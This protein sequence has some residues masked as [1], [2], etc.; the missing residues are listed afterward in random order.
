MDPIAWLGMHSI[1]A[2]FPGTTAFV[3]AH[4]DA[5]T[6]TLTAPMIAPA[7]ATSEVGGSPTN[8]TANVTL[9]NGAAPNTA[10]RTGVIQLV[11]TSNNNTVLA[12]Q[13][14]TSATVTS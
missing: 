2:A 12:T 7:I 9:P 5:R 11:D 6:L 13:P 4:S 14:L 10:M 1:E 8:S 3:A